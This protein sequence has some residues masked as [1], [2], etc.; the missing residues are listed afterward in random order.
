MNIQMNNLNS[1]AGYNK[2]FDQNIQQFN[3]NFEQSEA[4]FEKVLNQ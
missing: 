3:K 1:I 2:I 4:E